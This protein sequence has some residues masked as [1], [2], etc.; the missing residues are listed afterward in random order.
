MSWLMVFI[1]YLSP[2][3]LLMF[4]LAADRWNGKRVRVA[5]APAV[6]FCR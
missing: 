2:L 5:S 3:A 4:V 1:S 6:K